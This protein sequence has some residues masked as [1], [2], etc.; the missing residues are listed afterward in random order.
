MKTN[1]I[2]R[3][4]KQ[5][6][7]AR[8]IN[9]H[10]ASLL[11]ALISALMAAMLLN[12]AGTPTTDTTGISLKEY[13][14]LTWEEKTAYFERI[15]RGGQVKDR[16]LYEAALRDP[17]SPVTIAALKAMS[18]DL[19]SAMRSDIHPLL[20]HQDSMVRWNA[21]VN[22]TDKPDDKDLK[23]LQAMAGDPEWLCRECFFK[24]LRSYE[25]EQK[26]KKY[27]FRVIAAINEKNIN[28]LRQIYRTLIW[29]DDERAYPYLFK[30]TYHTDSRM[31]L[32]AI[33]Q[34]L[35]AL[36]NEEVEKLLQKLAARHKDFYVRN[37]AARLLKGM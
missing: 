25:S 33:I 1:L 5:S 18:L 4:D 22:L 37:E 35:A 29:Y 13:S 7:G 24:G 11:H 28:V 2:H 23:R 15:P 12:C 32:I 10:A 8:P 16:S 21:C 6:F 26:K 3:A 17:Y 20:S 31:E 14:I 30:R 34:E 19:I 36:D 9:L 27:F